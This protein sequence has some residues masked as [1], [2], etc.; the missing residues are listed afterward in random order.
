MDLLYCEYNIV[1][2]TS[3]S[4]TLVLWT[5]NGKGIATWTNEYRNVMISKDF[6]EFT[7]K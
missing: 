4:E 1:A 6:V 2:K 5:F 7:K 3:P